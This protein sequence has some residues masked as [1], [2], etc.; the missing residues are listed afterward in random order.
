[1][2]YYLKIVFRSFLRHKS[3]SLINLIGLTTGLICA[4]FIFL[5]VQ[6]EYAFDK[7]HEKD[8]RLYQVMGLES[9]ANEQSV[10]TG[11]PGPLGESLK[12]DFPDIQYAATTTWINPGLLSYENTF[13]REDGYHVGKDFFHIFTYPLLAGDP[14]TVL[15]DRNSICIS[16]DLAIK[17]FGNVEG[18]VGKT[19][20]YESS[21]DFTV[22]GVFENISDKS[23][24]IFDFVLPF[25]YFL[26]QAEWAN[27]WGNTGPSTYVVLQDGVKAEVVSEKISGYV[28]TKAENS[29]VE[30]FLKQYST[31][32]LQGRYTNGVADGGRID[33][34]RLF[35]VIAIFILLIA[36]INF[37]NL[38]T[39]RASRRAVEVG[40]RKAIGAGRAELIRHYLG[41][42]LLMAF[43]ALFIA[44]GLSG[45]L[46]GPFNAITG[47]RIALAFSSELIAISILTVLATGILAGS[48]PAFY[49]SHFKPI[50]VL[51][52]DIKRSIGEIWARKGLVVFQFAITIVLII[53]VVVIHRQTQYVNTKPLGYDRDNV[54]L[55]SQ[56]GN[57]P[58]QRDAFFNEL[59]NIPGVVHAAGTSH[60]LLG[61]ESS[62]PG[63]EW[64]GKAPDERI[65][66]ERFYVDPEFYEAMDFQ[67]TEGRWFSRAYA[68]D[69]TKMIINEAAAKAMGFSAEEAIGRR[70]TLWEGFD[71]EIIG[72]LEDFHYMSLHEAVQPAYFRMAGTWNVVARLEAGRETEALAGIEALYQ[73]FAPGYIFDYAFM[74]KSYQALYESEKRVGTLSSF[75]ASFA[76]IISCLGIFGLAAFTAER[77]IKEIG[78]RKVLGASTSNIVM[79]L[80]RD[81]IYLVFVS[82]VIA[83][84]VSFYFM[85]EWLTQ[86]AYKIDLS[87]WIFLGAS[88]LALGIAWLTVSSQALRAASV[89]P[90][91]CLKDE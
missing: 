54:I 82:I 76:I 7:F 64:E 85:Q 77:R 66:F 19:I 31:Q 68:T 72:V 81:F 90:A 46:I 11:T 58:T 4:F 15:N 79:M 62:N 83:V 21:Q 41:E 1:M 13:L 70:I 88:V 67:M 36:C 89:N 38:S 5:W 47:K 20:R 65:L 55:F 8:D 18:A 91:K 32:Y 16:R 9:F 17:F 37:M 63:L 80:S 71:L 48:Y 57:I 30:L 61:Q 50:Q 23:T 49:L 14:H 35:V 69:S 59:R 73:E 27:D 34:V 6:D 74:D 44:Y 84:P 42:A 10:S 56:N 26:D 3:S 75:F 52:G 2:L 43:L 12:A 25:Q 45:L 33:Y 51:K 24:Y 78:I 40:V 29:K 39:A 86:F 53:G 60:G 87:I 28:K 22:S